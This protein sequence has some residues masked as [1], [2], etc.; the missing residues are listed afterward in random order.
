MSEPFEVLRRELMDRPD[1]AAHA[2][3]A[4]RDLELEVRVEE[5]RRRPGEWVRV[6]DYDGDAADDATLSALIAEADAEWV[7]RLVPDRRRG[8][9]WE[10]AELVVR[11]R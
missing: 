2:A 4:G 3:E 8:L 1:A 11:F 5:A 6:C 9:G 10:R 7:I